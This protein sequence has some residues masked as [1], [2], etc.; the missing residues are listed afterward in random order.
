MSEPVVA[1]Q[2]K[3]KLVGLV[4][5]PKAY[6]TSRIDPALTVNAPLTIGV[7]VAKAATAPPLLLIVKLR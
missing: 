2:Y 4:V 6:E 1:P 3:A 7:A 5:P